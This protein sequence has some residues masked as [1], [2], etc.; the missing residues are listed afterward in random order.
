LSTYV[1]SVSPRSK[2]ALVTTTNRAANTEVTETVPAGEVWELV[3]VSISLVQGATQTPQPILTIDDGTSVIWAGPG[4]TTAQAVN[5]TCRYTWAPGHTL[6][7]LIGATTNVNSFAP[8]PA[9]LVLVAG[10][11]ITTNTIGIGANSDYA[12]PQIMVRK[13]K[14]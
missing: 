8:L 1:S 9:G 13:A 12:A 14:G 5:T 4:S 3:S 11:R 10:S 2:P 7:G 6:T